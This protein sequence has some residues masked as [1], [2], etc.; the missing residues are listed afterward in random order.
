M[1]SSHLRSSAASASPSPAS[2][3]SEHERRC[4]VFHVRVYFPVNFSSVL[5][6]S[7]WSEGLLTISAASLQVGVPQ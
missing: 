6:P 3:T 1:L 4:H 2:A 5:Q 7:K